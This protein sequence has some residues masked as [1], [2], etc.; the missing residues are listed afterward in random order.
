MLN[1]I[2][3]LIGG[4][5]E[6]LPDGVPASWV[7]ILRGVLAPVDTAKPGGRRGLA[8]DLLSY[9]LAGEP[10]AVLGEV[11]QAAGV[12][13]TLQITGHS[14]GRDLRIGSKLY[15]QFDAI[16]P[17]FLLRWGR[18]IAACV[19]D[20]RY[21][22]TQFPRG[23]H[24]LEALLIHAS[25]E[26]VH[27]YGSRSSRPTG[28]TGQS[29]DRLCAAA[30]LA[31]S[32]WLQSAFATSVQSHYGAS[33]RL[34]TFTR[35]PDFAAAVTRHAEALRPLLLPKE[36]DQRVHVLA[37]LAAADDAALAAFPA[38]L[39]E[40][41]TASSK[42]VRAAAEPL[43]RRLSGTAR[44][45]LRE[46][47][48][49]A[50]P[51][52]RLL[53]LRLAF[54]LARK[55]EDA[56][57]QAELRAIAAADKAPSIQALPG[58]WDG[59]AQRADVVAT[60]YDYTL[61]TIAWEGALTPAVAEMLERL[62]GDID[63]LVEKQYA[64]AREH[65]ERAKAEGTNAIAPKT[66]VVLR[67]K[68]L[69]RLR[70]YI[71][72]GEPKLA[73][74]PALGHYALWQHAA[75]VLP[76]Y[77]GHDAMSPVVLLKTLN[78]LGV[79]VASDRSLYFPAIAA[80]NALNAARGAPTLLELSEMLSAMR[81][82]GPQRVL[83]AYCNTGAALAT[84]WDRDAVWPFFA[85]HLDALID[86][87]APSAALSYWF[88]RD[89]VYRA[90][91]TLPTPP[92]T[93]VDALF[94]LAL[95]TT[96]SER[97]S[98]Q[99]ALANLP[100]KEQRIIAAL[101]SGKAE[102]RTVAAVWLTRL[103][104]VEAQAAL[105][106]A[107]AKEKN[108]V[109]KGA[110]LDALQALGQPV[111]KYLDR[112]ALVREAAKS[113]A[114]GVP[115]DLDGFPLSGL[116]AVHWQDDGEPVPAEVLTWLLVQAVKQK[117][118]E[119]NAVLRKYCAMFVP[120]DREA[121]ADYVLANWLA[122]DV[123]PVP[124]DD[125]M[126]RA[127]QQAVSMH[128]YMNGPQA[129]YFKD[130]PNFGLGVDELYARF[131]PG[132]LRQPAGSAIASKGLLAVVAACAG[133]SAAA[134]VARYL[135]EWYG[136]RA[137][138]GKALIAMLAWIESPSATQLML[139]VGSR[140]RTK[141]FQDEANRQAEALAERKGWTLA[142]LADRTI[143]SAGF[144]ETGT[145]ELSYGGRVFSARLLP[146]F[147]I[148][149]YN[150]EGK[151]IAALPEPRQDD[152]AALAKEA[153]KAYAAAKKEIKSIVTLQGERL[154]EALCTERDWSF[155]DW[156]L[157]LNQHPIVRKLVQRLV[158][159][160]VDGD[161]AG[162]EPAR[163]FRPLDD[164]SLTDDDDNAVEIAPTCRVRIA[165]D[166]HLPAATVA[167]W[168][169]HLKDYEIVP[170]FPQFGKG[171]YDLPKWAARETSI[172]AF[173]G[174]LIEAFA[175]RGKATKLGY[176]RGPTEDGGWFF[177]YEKRFPTLGLVATIEFTGNPLPEQ[178]RTVALLKLSF[179]S[180]KGE[181]WQRPALALSTIPKVLL[182]ECYDDL[183][184]IAAEGSG[185][186]PDWQKKSEY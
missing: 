61:P 178:N 33:S 100:G 66:P 14:F 24:W 151:K 164:G 52:Q 39:A 59:G 30:E 120:R 101:A 83:S 173:E 13:E 17:V 84:Q 89:G 110:M 34:M 118:P 67:E 162:S 71:A 103:A 154:Y 97:R 134:P 28:I 41:A 105:E 157:Y 38:E 182:S 147:K 122:A 130:D 111:E 10:V 20:P 5:P 150:P 143:P 55:S 16:D 60:R 104:C 40:L 81:L 49:Q 171:G 163:C 116:P 168:Q 93:L 21:F 138:Q 62:L 64:Q 73:G 91:A 95:G 99:D 87:L 165:H 112:A 152:D 158:W 35:L 144:D 146:D 69:G 53:A 22:C 57:W 140:F 85:H 127:R 155:E 42:Q 86:C 133:R 184:L 11:H 119:P 37:L 137:A 186:H 9:V 166:S 77:M 132:F 153:K 170:L 177:S 115:K 88:D 148:E 78:F 159:T 117:S 175:L 108:D 15:P 167:R 109:A 141:G 129:Q 12:G 51:D 121:L 7:E 176:T 96:K 25:G 1:W 169:Q 26:S 90:I 183:R 8:D 23:E 79:L 82:D 50:K 2:S 114:K 45:P 123:R 76:N 106:K 47:A 179:A 126:T 94:D 54:T 145:L 4:K 161:P 156:S 139:S 160:V 46:L 128:G 43:V 131:L 107:V 32:A 181:S 19:G 92:A 58:E 3:K 124:A 29:L 74:E 63:R 172:S 6:A 70:D 18:L 75:A 48:T 136:T 135:K 113:L 36:V 185:F 142:E 44:A 72:S 31:P 68:E 125:A 65:Y 174:H 80:I 180:S 98:A 27:S 56:A 102:V 149:L